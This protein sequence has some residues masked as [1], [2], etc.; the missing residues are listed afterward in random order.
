MGAFS[1]AKYL[2]DMR[3]SAASP[4]ISKLFVEEALIKAREA[5]QYAASISIIELPAAQGGL[6]AGRLLVISQS[7][8]MPSC[9]LLIKHL[10]PSDDCTLSS[11]FG[12]GGGNEGSGTPSGK[13]L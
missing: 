2:W 6:W 4:F 5:Q 7:V 11:A 12:M 9:Y 3:N 8:Q 1:R 13:V 10:Y